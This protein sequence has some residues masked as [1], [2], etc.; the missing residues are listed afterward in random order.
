MFR[1][2]KQLSQ[3]DLLEDRE[4]QNLQDCATALLDFQTIAHDRDDHV[5]RHGD[6]SL[7][8]SGVLRGAEERFGPTEPLDP[9]QRAG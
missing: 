7:V 6:P 5:H 9:N 8:L 2:V 1:R 4:T 3:R